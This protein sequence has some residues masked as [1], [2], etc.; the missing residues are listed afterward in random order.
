MNLS[1]LESAMKGQFIW[2][3]H[4]TKPLQTHEEYEHSAGLGLMVFIGMSKN[5]GFE[6]K[7]V[8]EHLAIESDE[9]DHKLSL[10]N[11]HCSD[12]YAIRAAGGFSV[13]CEDESS[14][15]KTIRKVYFKSKLVHNYIRLNYIQTERLAL[16]DLPS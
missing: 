13:K 5:L 11:Q 9:Y 10:Y 16:S 6:K 7:D 14:R 8:L 12:A 1:L 3:D 15:M 2:K 4:E